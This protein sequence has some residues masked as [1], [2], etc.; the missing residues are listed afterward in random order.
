M[1]QR[2]LVP[3]DGSPTSNRGLDEAIKL[4]GLCGARLR[5]VHVVDEMSL[6]LAMDAYSGYVGDWLT[7]LRDAGKQLL[8]QAV[9]RVKAAGVEADSCM[10][11]SLS[12]SI[13]DLIL[14]EADHW[15]A[16]LI[17]LGTH[18]RRGPR[19]W[20]LG[21]TAEDIVRRAPVPVLLVRASENE[22]AASEQAAAKGKAAG[23]SQPAGALAGA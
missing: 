1:Y 9:A 19:R 6:A 17:V 10:F 21:S 3:V 5:L 23:A 14:H 2:I 8:E 13:N 15:N 7:V 22:L 18:G 16:E 4:A 11:D 20:V 12:G